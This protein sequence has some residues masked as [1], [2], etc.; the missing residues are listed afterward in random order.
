M[1]HRSTES[2]PYG[3]YNG[4]TRCNCCF[5]LRVPSGPSD[6][7][8]ADDLCSHAGKLCGCRKCKSG[9]DPSTG[10]G[11]TAYQESDEGYH[12]L[13][14]ASSFTSTGSSVISYNI[15]QSVQPRTATETRRNLASQLALAMLPGGKGKVEELQKD[16]GTKDKLTQHWLDILFLKAREAYSKAPKTPDR[17]EAVAFDLNKWLESQPGEKWNPLL[18]IPG[19]TQ[20]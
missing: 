7:P 18:D 9:T 20:S 1:H 19:M 6:N 10:K 5:I 14:Q 12:T 2:E 17:I 4:H 11:S 15:L 13:Y 3:A 8:Q 16:T